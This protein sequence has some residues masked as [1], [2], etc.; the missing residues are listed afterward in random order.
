MAKVA[1]LHAQMAEVLAR[2]FRDNPGMCAIYA[3]AHADA[4]YSALRIAS[5]GFVQAAARH[6]TVDVLKQHGVVMAVALA[7]PPGGYPLPFSFQLRMLPRVLRAGPPAA[8]R[9]ARMDAQ[10]HAHHP[11]GDHAYLWFLGVEPALQGRGLG[12]QLL[13]QHTQRADE[14]FLPAYLETD[15]VSSVRPYER[16]GYEVVQTSLRPAGL[17]FTMWHMRRPARSRA[18]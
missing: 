15:K 17:S 14:A 8:I 7:L 1:S 16:H 3:G 10:M 13:R 18:V 5:G 9:L 2:A 6:G 4:R 12:S 11:A